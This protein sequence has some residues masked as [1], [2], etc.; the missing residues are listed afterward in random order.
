MIYNYEYYDP[1]ENKIIEE[2]M[3][4]GKTLHF[5]YGDFLG[6][7]LLHLL[8]KRIWWG[9][10]YR[11][12]KKSSLS[13]KSIARDIKRFNI[14]MDL[15]EVEEWKSYN[16]FFSRYFKEGVRDFSSRTDELAAFAEGKYLVYDSSLVKDIKVKDEILSLKR[17]ISCQS[18]CYYIVCR[19]CPVDYHHYHYPC[20]GTLKKSYLVRGA[21]D[22][23]NIF[24]QKYKPLI[25]FRNK[26]WVNV[27]STNFGEI[28]YIEVG[29]MSVGTIKNLHQAGY[30]FNKGEMK[31]QFEYGGSSL[32]MVLPKD[33][34][35]LR[36][37][38]LTHS[39]LGRETFLKL[40]DHLGQL[41]N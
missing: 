9:F 31:G 16:H 36:E 34:I 22:S 27:L 30:D 21:Y 8:F 39:K 26:R 38:V 35:K 17:T 15:Y 18:E 14:D 32:V 4:F 29:G 3:Y 25:L 40:G 20:A 7:V 12:Y 10:I 24:A 1:Y 2:E 37:D 5:F 28:L 13:I 11:C 19:L 6:K 33:K 41:T 23:V